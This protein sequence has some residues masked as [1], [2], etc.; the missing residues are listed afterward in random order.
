M[1]IAFVTC[2]ALDG[3]LARDDRAL[4]AALERR[5]ARVTAAVWDDARVAW[6]GFEAIVLRSCWDYH[7]RP[8]AFRAWLRR[9]SR[10]PTW[11]PAPLVLANLHKRYLLQLAAVGCPIVR[12]RLLPAGSR[13]ELQG[14]LAAEQWQE[15]VVKPAI[16]ATAYRTW[17][18]SELSIEASQ[19]ALERL[20]ADSDVLVQRFVPEVVT[21]GELSFIFFAGAFSHA[22]LKSARCGE[23]R[24]QSDFG[25]HARRIAPARGQ[26]AVAAK[27]VETIPHP[28]LYARVDAVEVD[29]T[30]QVME[31][32]LI[33]PEL[34]ITTAPESAEGFCDALSLLAKRDPRTDADAR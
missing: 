22:V 13:C 26:L 30:L 10:L 34:F 15:A 14:L 1:T 16:G 2:R 31:L 23:F 27:L 8:A 18:T 11:N 24:V 25:G 19:Q 20:L 33:E 3:A 12:T 32:E 6:E 28:W 29:G 21:Q 4:A 5:G 7:R 17:R 9:C